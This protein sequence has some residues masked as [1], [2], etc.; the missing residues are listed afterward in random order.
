MPFV[1]S[2]RSILSLLYHEERPQ[3]AIIASH[4]NCHGPRRKIMIPI[5]ISPAILGLA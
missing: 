3:V 5:T 4:V 1:S 2:F